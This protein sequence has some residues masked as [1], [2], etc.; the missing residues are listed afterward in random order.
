[1]KIAV[2]GAGAFGTALAIS[3]ARTGKDITL[4]ARNEE[5]ALQIKRS[6]TL[7]FLKT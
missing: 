3:L 2:A 7:Q 5:A 6:Q 1:M 4:V